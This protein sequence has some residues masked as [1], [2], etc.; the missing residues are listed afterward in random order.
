MTRK[1]RILVAEDNT[2]ARHGILS[3]LAN[4]SEFKSGC[5]EIVGDVDNATDA[6]KCVQSL[7]PDVITLDL[8]M[9]GINGA[10]ALATL[11]RRFPEIKV[12]VLTVHDELPYIRACFSAGADG[13]VL[14]GDS[15]ADLPYAISSALKNKI[16]LSPSIG[17]IVI[18]A[19]LNRTNGTAQG[20][21]GWDILTHRQRQ[22]ITLIA[23]G[24]TN[25]EI[26]DVLSLSIKTVE[27][28]RST[29][30]KKLDVHNA[31][32]LTAYAIKHGLVLRYC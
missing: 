13:Y 19:L 14:K 8:S 2:Y 1:F 16:Y 21:S 27:N 23:E 20:T 15:E 12:I 25:S 31:S 32:E 5:M 29:L 26:A 22:I 24:K 17:K 30:M 4:S 10:D 18:K 28:H 3:I 6:I 11:K 9:P 7:Q